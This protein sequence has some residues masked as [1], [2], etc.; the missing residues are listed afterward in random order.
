[1]SI[2]P[3]VFNR[4]TAAEARDLLASLESPNKLP[5][6]A[7]EGAVTSV[8]GQ[9]GNVTIDIPGDMQP[10]SDVLTEFS[11]LDTGTSG[12]V[13]QE[14]SKFSIAPIS[15]FVR[16][17]FSSPND[18]FYRGMLGLGDGAV[19]DTNVPHGIPTLNEDGKL[20]ASALDLELSTVS[21]TGSYNDLTDKPLLFNGDYN[22]L[23]NLPNLFTGNY[24]DLVN[25]PSLFDGDYNS[26]TNK[27]TIPTT[28]TQIAEGTNLY[29]TDARVQSYLT[30]QNYRKVETLQG[31]TNLFGVYQVTFAN[32][33][34]APP[35]VNPFIL[36]GTAAQIATVSNLTTTGCTVT[37]HQRNSLTLLGLEVL[38]A[39]TVPVVNSTVGVLV[40]AKA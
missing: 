17:L 6:S 30:A 9:T 25:K 35:H 18:S 28:T 32:S 7:I 10:L 40:V 36:N 38:L 23:T 24:T 21:Q 16:N 27:P 37:V 29:H 31:V 12:V 5:I 19:L 15:G 1:M 20:D 3:L 33:Y 2:K 4:V 22:S 26:L 13:W 8:N 39:A 34:A 11:E 14:N